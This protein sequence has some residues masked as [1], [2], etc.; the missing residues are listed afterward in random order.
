M[1]FSE[2]NPELTIFELT[3]FYRLG[4]SLRVHGMKT[5]AKYPR[6]SGLDYVNVF[7]S[8]DNFPASVRLN[9]S[10]VFI[11]DKTGEHKTIQCANV[12]G[13]VDAILMEAGI[14]RK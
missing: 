1:L 11:Q 8:T 10:V 12:Q 5:R 3:N 9:T 7:V 6:G 4:I 13:C 2:V 14:Q